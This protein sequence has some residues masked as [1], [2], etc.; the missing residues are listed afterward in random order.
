VEEEVVVI[1]DAD[2]RLAPDCIR[3]L[4]EAL[5]ADPRAALVGARVVPETE[6]PEER[7]HWALVG[8]LSWLEGEVL[9]AAT[10]SGVALA[11]RRDAVELSPAA[12]CDDVHLA[13]AAG[14][15][16][17]RV[18]L[19]W[20]SVAFE[21]RVPRTTAGLLACRRRRGRAFRDEL[22]RARSLGAAS[23][24][25]RLVRTMRLLLFDVVPWALVALGLLG[26]GLAAAGAHR[27]ALA[28]AFAFALPLVGFAAAAA[29]ERRRAPRL[30][31]PLRWAA[32]SLLAL[33][34][35]RGRL[36]AA[37]GAP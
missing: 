10:P 15:R 11:F 4:V 34:T 29:L 31:A 28:G 8:K 35:L 36:G 25:F 30:A 32:L 9:G 23:R 22:A 13:V 37:E 24:G 19:A 33:V 26:A 1:S 16:G 18:K 6:L 14:R 27:L 17:H 5:A 3:G 12:V 21:S 7:L 2:A 20:H